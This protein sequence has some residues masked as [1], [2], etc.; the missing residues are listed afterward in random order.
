MSSQPVTG[1]AL[2]LPFTFF[3]HLQQ[4]VGRDFICKEHLLIS[5]QLRVEEIM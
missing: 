4:I 1:T 5:S 3:T 2:P